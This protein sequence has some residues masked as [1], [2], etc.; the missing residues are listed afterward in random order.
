ML[1]LLLE[2][3]QSTLLQYTY[4]AE[5]GAWHSTTPALPPGGHWSVDSDHVHG[6]QYLVR[7]Q[8]FTVPRRQYLLSPL[9]P[10]GAQGCP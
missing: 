2:N 5:L 1:V 4:D 10:P 6:D 8:D 9:H 3:V 7:T